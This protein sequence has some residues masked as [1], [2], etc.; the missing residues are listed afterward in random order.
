M[1]MKVPGR[2]TDS[3]AGTASLTTVAAL[4]DGSTYANDIAALR[5]N[6]A[7]LTGAANSLIDWCNALE[8]RL[9]ALEGDR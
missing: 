8:K 1:S 7:T 4:A 6:L 5:N 9:A 2:L 3:S